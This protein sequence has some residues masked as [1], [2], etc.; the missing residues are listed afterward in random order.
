MSVVKIM[1]MFMLLVFSASQAIAATTDEIAKA[2][3]KKKTVFL[4]VTDPGS[5]GIEQARE[6]IK[7]A[8]KQVKNSTMIEFDRSNQAN[9]ALVGQYR[10]AG[11]P[12]P[13]ILLLARNGA[14][15]GGVPA[16]QATAEQLAKMVPTDSKAEV[17]KAVQSG[18][19]VLVT[20]TS[21]RMPKESKASSACAAACSQMQG[22]C[23]S[24]SLDLDDEDELPFLTELK[25]NPQA[26]EPVTVVINA[27]GQ[28]TGSFLGAVQVGSLVQAATKK[29]GGCCPGGS[30]SSSG[31]APAKK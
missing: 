30:S 15:A 10:L 26:T 24:V 1:A 22:K 7:S 11:A 6:L 20:A 17:L 3:E 12:L 9:A 21:K 13:L 8:C 31:C 25:I 23:S 29:I 14:V 18:Q 19:S 27:Q 28:V 2:S 5:Q 16:G 4:L